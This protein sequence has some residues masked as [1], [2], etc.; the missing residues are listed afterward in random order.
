[1]K[2]IH[3][4][5]S[6]GTGGKLRVGLRKS[7][8]LRKNEGVIKDFIRGEDYSVFNQTVLT[9]IEAVPKLRRDPDLNAT[10]EG[11]GVQWVK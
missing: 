4:Y 3:G 8:G 1:M 9:L 6:A 11:I 2:V 7:F 10:N 5:G